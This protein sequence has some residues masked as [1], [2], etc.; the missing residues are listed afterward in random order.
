MR[1]GLA[2]LGRVDGGLNLVRVDDAGEVGHRH[3]VGGGLP[4]LLGGR[5]HR[6]GSVDGVELLEG[7][8]GPDD[9]PADV[10]AGREGE[11]A[12]AVHG[13][14]LH[15]RDV[16]HRLGDAR[17]I[18]VHDERA[19]ALD[20]AAVPHLTLTGAKVAGRLDLLDVGVGAN[21]LE[22]L[23][24][25]GRLGDGLGGVVQDEGHLGDGLDVVAASHE[26]GGDRGGGERGADGVALLLEVHA[27]VPPA[28]G[29]VRGRGEGGGGR[30]R[31]I[32]ATGR[33]QP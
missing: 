17:V 19:L 2:L 21:L 14:Q 7:G 33:W 1:A 6:G 8:L 4:A 3:D 20:V 11:E 10:T 30:V 24:R 32:S 29:L 25:L 13:A 5:L 18:R 12:E 31:L 9:E 15:A 28:P 22:E 26:E 27:P 16:P 23:H